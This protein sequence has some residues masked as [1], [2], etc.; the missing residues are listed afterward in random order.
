MKK[1]KMFASKIIFRYQ[2][3][4]PLFP[5]SDPMG[6]S[7]AHCQQNFSLSCK[8]LSRNVMLSTACVLGKSE[9]EKKGWKCSIS[10]V[11][12]LARSCCS[13]LQRNQC[14]D[15]VQ[16][17]LLHHH[18]QKQKGRKSNQQKRRKG[19]L[20][21]SR[22]SVFSP[23]FRCCCLHRIMRF[24]TRLV[25]LDWW[26]GNKKAPSTF[27]T[28]KKKVCLQLAARNFILCLKSC[29]LCYCQ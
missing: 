18:G 28:N 21:V 2:A 14:F 3:S 10:I 12:P 16:Q 8:E 22:L 26:R 11:K 1:C 23:K 27:Q 6:C 9:N 4:T 13:Y 24:K 15:T 17:S 7:S 25:V 20:C 5:L 19:Q 29:P